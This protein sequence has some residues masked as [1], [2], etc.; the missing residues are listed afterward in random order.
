MIGIVLVAAALDQDVARLDVAV[1]QSQ[2]VGGVEGAGRLP[3]QRERLVGRQPVPDLQDRA[4][5]SAV[6]YRIAI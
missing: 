3:D 2:P 4:Q 1:D 6:T 5:V